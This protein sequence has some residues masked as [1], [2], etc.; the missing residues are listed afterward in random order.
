MAKFSDKVLPELKKLHPTKNVMELPK[1]V[2]IVVNTCQGEA[3][4]NIKAL[5]A[6]AAELEI[7][8]GQKAII[9]RAKKS[10]ATFKLRAGMPIGA[11]VTLR[12]ERM[13]EFYDKLVSVAL[14]R[15][16]DFRGVS[17]NSFDGRGNYSLGIREQI[18]FPEIE[19]DKVDKTRGLSITIVTSA[20][21][22]GEARELLT[23]LDMPFRK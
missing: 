18:I 12:K 4:Q 10:I 11:S 2:K 8:T 19:A 5:E 22:D 13:F 1:I 14:P 15:V 16:R 6:A 3:T 17:S 20:K 9:T 21:T 7:I 23:L